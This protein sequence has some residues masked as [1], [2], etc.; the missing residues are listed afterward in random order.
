MYA[1]SPRAGN[2][3]GHAGSR[4]NKTALCLEVSRLPILK[5]IRGAEADFLLNYCSQQAQLPDLVESADFCGKTSG[6]LAGVLL[7]KSKPTA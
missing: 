3:R 1:N 7:G 2:T 4:K 5:P 6:R